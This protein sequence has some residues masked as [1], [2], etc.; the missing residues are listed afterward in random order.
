MGDQL[1]LKSEFEAKI[2]EHAGAGRSEELEEVKIVLRGAKRKLRE[3]GKED[4]GGGKKPLL[5]GDLLAILDTMGDGAKDVRDK[6][7][8][9][10]GW[11]A[12]LRRSEITSL[13]VC[14]IQ[15]DPRGILLRLGGKG[16]CVPV[17]RRDKYCPVASLRSWLDLVG[18][19]TNGPVFRTINNGHITDRRMDGRDV[20]RLIQS[21]VARIGIDSRGYAGHSLRSG[22]VVSAG[23]GDPWQEDPAGK[24]G[25]R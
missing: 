23:A 21:H 12:A 2:L 9:L 5:I 25:L 13:D 4:K 6:A 19:P 15:D 8:L 3:S 17:R 1:V 20:A 14:D 7:L 18:N 11:S 10:V 22:L 24:A 16:H